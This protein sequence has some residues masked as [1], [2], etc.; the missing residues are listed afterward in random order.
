[1]PRGKL[2]CVR[3]NFRRKSFFVHQRFDV[4]LMPK[5]HAHG[6]KICLVAVA[7]LISGLLSD[8]DNGWAKHKTTGSSDPCASPTAFVNG[9]IAK[10]RGLLKSMDAGT[11]GNISAWISQLEGQKKSVDPDKTAQI[12]ELRRDADSVNDLLGAGGCKTIDIDQE[13]AKPAP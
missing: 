2:S 10:I 13:L 12:S 7:A 9:Q 6:L 8:A 3:R 5:H 1:M 11:A 4:G